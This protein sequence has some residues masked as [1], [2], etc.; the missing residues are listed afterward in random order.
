MYD[1]VFSE[2]FCDILAK[3]TDHGGL[4]SV[5]YSKNPD[6][7]YNCNAAIQSNK[8]VRFYDGVENGDIENISYFV[9]KHID[10]AVE[11][12]IQDLGYQQSFHPSRYKY[13]V[14]TLSRYLNNNQD[15]YGLHIG[16]DCICSSSKTLMI[17]GL[18]NHVGEGGEISFPDLGVNVKLNTGS[19]LIFPGNWMFPFK[20][21][22]PV[23]NPQYIFN[24]FTHFADPCNQPDV[25]LHP[26]HQE[27]VA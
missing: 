19:I 1:G 9:F 16:S 23:S 2:E 20:I 6:D 18:L 24:T 22:K 21:N 13:E 27:A 12:Y 25:C 10:K 3:K 26:I 5:D 11:H 17:I 4:E 14:I 7:K 15:E 8:T